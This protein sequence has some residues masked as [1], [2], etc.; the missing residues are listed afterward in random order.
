MI[1]VPQNLQNSCFHTMGAVS[2]PAM[3]YNPY[4]MLLSC[5]RTSTCCL[6]PTQVLYWKTRNIRERFQ[7]GP[8]AMGA[9][10]TLQ[11][12]PRPAE[13]LCKGQKAEFPSWGTQRYSPKTTAK[14]WGCWAV[15]T[16]VHVHI[17][18]SCRLG[19][20]S[21]GMSCS[22]VYNIYGNR[23]CRSVCN[24]LSLF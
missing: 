13:Y 24:L 4:L 22:V 19:H 21:A 8:R 15:R 10:R 6:N 11:S 16:R 9:L 1:L 12:Y 23:F 2:A 3:L 17:T 7:S 5:S 20:P 14:L 18:S